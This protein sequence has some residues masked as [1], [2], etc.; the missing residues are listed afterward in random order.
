M[1]IPDNP[2]IYHIVHVDRLPSI[3]ADGFIWSDAEA[4]RRGAPGTTIGMGAIKQRRL[5]ELPLNSHPGLYVGECVPFYFCPRSVMLYVLHMANAPDLGYR[6][7]QGPIIHLEADL[8]QAVAWAD[9]NRRRWAFTT[10]NAASY[11]FRDYCDLAQL[12]EI[13]W[14]AV[15][16][17]DWRGLQEG[18][19]AEFLVEHSFPWSLVK[20]IGVHSLEI[21]DRVRAMMRGAGHQPVVEAAPNWYY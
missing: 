16:A 1:P 12:D 13:D 11:R 5:T 14:N 17:H 20:R 6:D 9:A 8:R 15:Q 18:K 3:I 2:K 21:R 10:S 19:Q 4:G 7:G